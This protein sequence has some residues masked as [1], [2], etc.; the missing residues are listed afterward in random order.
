M[1]RGA[2]D[3]NLGIVD[4]YMV[5]KAMRLKE[6]TNKMSIDRNKQTIKLGLS[7]IKRSVKIKEKENYKD[8]H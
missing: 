3:L 2:K 8:Q 7:N 4:I 1:G 6:I 5:F